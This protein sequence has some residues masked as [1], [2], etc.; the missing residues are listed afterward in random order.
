MIVISGPNA[1]SL[2]FLAYRLSV[3]SEALPLRG[4]VHSHPSSFQ[5]HAVL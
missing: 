3:V 4:E 5:C 2:M 1:L